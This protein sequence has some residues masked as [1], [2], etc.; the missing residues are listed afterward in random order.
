ML[1]L[2]IGYT[3]LAV[4]VGLLGLANLVP[5][6]AEVATLH[7]LTTGAF[8][9]MMLA[10]MTRATLGHSGRQLTAD[11]WTVAIYAAVTTGA[12]ARML[13]PLLPGEAWLQAAGL[14][15]AGAFLLFALVYGPMLLGTAARR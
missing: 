10:V 1:I 6:I 15:W 11:G 7:A 3:W 9:T 14:L 12:I 2:H 4:G 5:A 8:G 13:S